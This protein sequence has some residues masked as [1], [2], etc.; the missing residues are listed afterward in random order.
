MEDGRSCASAT[1]ISY[2]APVL[3]NRHLPHRARDTSR[4]RERYDESPIFTGNEQLLRR[5]DHRTWCDG[6]YRATS[7]WCVA[8]TSCGVTRS[9]K[10]T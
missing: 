10:V 8:R 7:P 2:V 4:A 5:R 9:T 6:E 3:G 1:V